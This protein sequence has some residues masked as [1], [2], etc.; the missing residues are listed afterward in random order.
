ML[1]AGLRDTTFEGNALEN[2]FGGRQTLFIDPDQALLSRFK[3]Y[4]NFETDYLVL[5][6]EIAGQFNTGSL[7][8]RVIVGADYDKFENDQVI[9]RYRP[10]FFSADTDINDLDLDQYL[11]VDIFNPDYSLCLMYRSLTTSTGW[12]YKRLGACI[13]KTKLTLQTSSNFA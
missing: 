5:R 6:G 13:F 7:T 4:R 9:L 3:R 11:V 1:G 12:K 8:H 10:P 2:N